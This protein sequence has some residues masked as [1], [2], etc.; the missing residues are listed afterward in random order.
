VRHFLLFLLGIALV[1]AAIMR[2]R[3]GGDKLYPDLF[4]T[5]LL[6]ASALE[7]VL[8][9]PEPIGNVAVSAFSRCVRPTAPI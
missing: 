3:Y 1:A 5:P 4:T 7:E 6:E 9:Y 8:S 2:V